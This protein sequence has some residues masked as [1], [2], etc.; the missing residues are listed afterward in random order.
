[1]KSAQRDALIFTHGGEW[2]LCCADHGS[3]ANSQTNACLSQNQWLMELLTSFM[4]QAGKAP[5]GETKVEERLAGAKLK[6][7]LRLVWPS[8]EAVRT[9]VKGWMSGG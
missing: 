9:S 1:M 3:L 7:H 5:S 4:A 6:E 2:G 8:V